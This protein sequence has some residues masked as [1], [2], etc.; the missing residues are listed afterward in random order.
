MLL[1]FVNFCNIKYCINLWVKY[2]CYTVLFSFKINCIHFLFCWYWKRC[3]LEYSE[4]YYS[5]SPS[6]GYYE[7]PSEGY[8][9]SPSSDGY[10]DDSHSEGY[11]YERHSEDYPRYQY[12]RPPPR[13]RPPPLPPRKVEHIKDFKHNWAINTKFLS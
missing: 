4:H 7:R 5:D 11:S 3:L 1:W 10:H 2:A 6:E 13:P 12:Q 9:E 8:Y